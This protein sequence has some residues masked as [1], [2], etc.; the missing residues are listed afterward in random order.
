MVARLAVRVSLRL[1]WISFQFAIFLSLLNIWSCHTWSPNDDRK[2]EAIFGDVPLSAVTK[3]ELDNLSTRDLMQLFVTSPPVAEE[4]LRGE[5][6]GQVLD[7]SAHAYVR[8]G[9]IIFNFGF[10]LGTWQGQGFSEKSG[11]NIFQNNKK[12][13]VRH[14]NFNLASGTSQIDAGPSMILDYSAHNQDYLTFTRKD[15][16]RVINE[17]LYLG[18]AMYQGLGG[19]YNPI[20]YVLYNPPKSSQF[21]PPNE[22]QDWWIFFQTKMVYL[23]LRVLRE[24]LPKDHND[25]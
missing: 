24:M 17:N 9:L 1:L 7:G 8:I 13:Q 5:F 4:K 12:G 3:R 25:L 22:K 18:M 2:P 21:L 11:Y 10:G 19:K 23:E 14:R 6:V 15:E 20:P 16:L